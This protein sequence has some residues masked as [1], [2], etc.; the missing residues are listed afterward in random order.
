MSIGMIGKNITNSAAIS[1][2]ASKI[3]I[4]PNEK[5]TVNT[6]QNIN[7]KWQQQQIQSKLYYAGQYAPISL[8]NPVAWSQFIKA[9]KRGDFKNNK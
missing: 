7:F 4:L 2:P 5:P 8:L 6:H 3:G 1:K 9:W